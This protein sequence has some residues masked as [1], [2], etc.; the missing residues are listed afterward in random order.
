MY[1]QKQFNHTADAEGIEQSHVDV[2]DLNDDD[3]EHLKDLASEAPVIKTVNH[4]LQKA[5]E[6]RA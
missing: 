3:L 6:D 2:V 5:V 4:I 1:L